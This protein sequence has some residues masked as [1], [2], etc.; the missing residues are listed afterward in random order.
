MI[1]FSSSLWE[2]LVL[3]N[4]FILLLSWGFVIKHEFNL[5]KHTYHGTTFLF[6]PKKPVIRHS[7]SLSFL[8]VLF[9]LLWNKHSHKILQLQNRDQGIESH[10]VV[11]FY[12]TERGCA[13]FGPPVMTKGQ[14]T[15]HL[16]CAFARVLS[17]SVLSFLEETILWFVSFLSKY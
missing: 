3:M 16:L 17:L 13:E 14:F 8:G 10:A 1:F 7:H 2:F 4:I 5:P 6:Y 12:H 15:I 9:Y 11:W